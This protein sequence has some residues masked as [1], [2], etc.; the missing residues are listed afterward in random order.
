[1]FRTTLKNL[2]ARKLRL[3]TTS[4]AVMLGVAFM[5]GTLV[6]T[7]TIG[8]TFDRLFADA[9]EGTDAYVRGEAALDSERLGDQRAR[10]DAS[11]VDTVARRRRCRRSR[12]LHRGLRPARRQRR[13]ADRQPRHG[14]ARL[15]GDWI[16]RRRAQPVRPRRGP[17]A[18][19]PTTRSSSTRAAPTTATSSS[20]TPSRCSPRPGRID[21]DDRRHRHASATPTAPAARRHAVHRRRRRRRTSPQPGKFDAIKVVG[22]GRRQPTRARR[23]ASHGVVPDGTEVLTG[24]EITEETAGRRQGGHGLLQHRSCWCSP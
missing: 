8:K 15:G 21:V 12:G 2:A 13:Q 18:R 6:L 4:L 7:D 24:A 5:A 11:L 22:R 23:A 20:A 9:Y 16:D 19:R 1:M 14:C 3:L 10:L 17:C